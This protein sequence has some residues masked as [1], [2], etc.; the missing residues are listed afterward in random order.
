MPL[1]KAKARSYVE[2]ARNA[3]RTGPRA[4]Y[5]QIG[6]AFIEEALNQL[7]QDSLTAS[8]AMN[9]AT[10]LQ[11]ELDDEKTAYRKLREQ[12]QHTEKYVALLREIEKSPKGAQRKAKDVLIE[13]GVSDLVL[14]RGAVIGVVPEKVVVP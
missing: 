7:D 10:R 11:R 5:I 3:Y 6:A 12:G 4:E 9:E 2:G 8:R 14:T 13:T 1:D